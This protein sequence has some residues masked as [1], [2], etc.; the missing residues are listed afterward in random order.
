ML[1]HLPTRSFI[2]YLSLVSYSKLYQ[3]TAMCAWLRPKKCI[4]FYVMTLE[5]NRFQKERQHNACYFA[6]LADTKKIARLPM[7][8]G[9]QFHLP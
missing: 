2:H 5:R 1:S 6:C 7:A 8:A 4:V 9:A 3:R